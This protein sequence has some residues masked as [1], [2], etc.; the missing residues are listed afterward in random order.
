M[1]S[2]G[3]YKRFKFGRI[4]NKKYEVWTNNQ[5]DMA[6]GGRCL[7]IDGMTTVIGI[8]RLI[9]TTDPVEMSFKTGASNCIFSSDSKEQCENFI[10]W[11]NCKFTRFFVAI[12]ISKLTGIL[13]DDYFRFVPAPLLKED[14]TYNWDIKYTDELLYNYYNLDDKYRQVI[15]SVI[16]ERK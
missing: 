14:G 5:A 12:N 7:T 10:S 2:L 3:D 8:S 1:H 4:L 11:L 15:E 13:T 9:D 6:G 16:K